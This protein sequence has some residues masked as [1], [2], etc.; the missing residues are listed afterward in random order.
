MDPRVQDGWNMKG[1]ED[2][3]TPS[4]NLASVFVLSDYAHPPFKLE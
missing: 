3:V 2:N 1:K 4:R